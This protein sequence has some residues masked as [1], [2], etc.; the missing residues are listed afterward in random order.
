MLLNRPKNDP[1]HTRLE[2]IQGIGERAAELIRQLLLFRRIAEPEKRPMELNKEIERAR[3]ILERT[4]PKMIDIEVNLSKD[5]MLVNADPVRM[6]QILLNLA[7][8]AAD[9]M[10][11]GGK[12][13][14]RTE[15]KVLDREFARSLLNGVAGKYVLL[16]VIDTGQ[17]MDKKVVEHIFEPFYTTK[18]IGKGTGLWPASVYGIAKSHGVCRQAISSYGIGGQNAGGPG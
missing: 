11:D 8:N 6:E 10:T 13:V 16:A 12:V 9:A 7:Q 14:I 1:N 2:A 5:L 18:D 17:G 3:L 4:L 15:N